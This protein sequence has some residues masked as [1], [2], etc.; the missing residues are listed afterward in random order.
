MNQ[1]VEFPSEMVRVSI[2]NHVIVIF[3]TK[4]KRKEKKTRGH[5]IQSYNL[6]TV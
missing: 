4:E 1:R 6:T 5:R 3:I 2:E